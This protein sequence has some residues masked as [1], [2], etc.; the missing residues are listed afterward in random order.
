MDLGNIS[1]SG[2]IVA[3]VVVNP[4][5]DSKKALIND[6]IVPL[7]MYGRVPNDKKISHDSVTTI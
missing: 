7:R 2:R 4:E 6:G 1:T 3:P 5:L